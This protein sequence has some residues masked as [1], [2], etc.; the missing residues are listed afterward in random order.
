VI[1]QFSQK[2][3]LLASIASVIFML[4]TTIPAQ[5]IITRHDVDDAI[6]LQDEGAY[7]A[8]FDVFAN[9]GGVATLIS[10]RWA[11]TAAHVGQDISPGHS[12][13]VA[14]KPYR[15]RRVVLH[16]DWESGR[17][18]MSLFELDRPVQGVDPIA[19]YEN[20][21]ELGQI[22]TF[23]G[24]GDSGNGLTGPT[25]KDHQLR[26]ATNL[27]ERVEGD[28]LVFRFDA[29]EDE[30]VTPLEGVSGPG[31]SGGPAFLVTDDGLRIAG[32]SVASSGRPPGTYGNWEFYSRVSPDVK[33]IRET[34]L[35]TGDADVLEAGSALPA[36]ESSSGVS[37]WSSTPFY[38]GLAILSA[39]ALASLFWWFR[40]RRISSTA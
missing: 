24:R 40:H 11:I 20:D 15:V 1:G 10:P 7:P 4:T 6:F 17:R 19:L 26:A 8:V 35:T 9:R 25:A 37:F 29:P 23:V 12:V 30:N 28:T 36:A 14:G 38:V 5:A 31:D 22:V 21:D 27:I 2:R 16:P 39:L 13:I 34:M 33:W 32:L 3:V 18:E